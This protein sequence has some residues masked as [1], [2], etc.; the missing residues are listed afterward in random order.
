[1]DVKSPFSRKNHTNLKVVNHLVTP[2]IE[3]D[4]TM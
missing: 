2:D 1:M 3:Q 4:V